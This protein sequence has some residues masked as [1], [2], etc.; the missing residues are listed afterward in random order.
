MRLLADPLAPPALPVQLVLR[1]PSLCL[2]SSMHCIVLSLILP[3]TLE[4]LLRFVDLSS[5]FEPA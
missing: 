4:A 1:S 3:S 2:P 5:I